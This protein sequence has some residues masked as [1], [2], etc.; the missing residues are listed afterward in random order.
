MIKIKLRR[1]LIY[2]L[3]YFIC[4]FLDYSVLGLVIPSVTGFNTLYICIYLYPI[5]NIIG[6]LVVFLYQKYS[7]RKKEKTQYFGIKFNKNKGASDGKFKIILLVFFAAY[8]NFYRFI[9]YAFVKNT[10]INFT[11]DLKLTTIQIIISTIICIYAFEFKFKKHHK[12]SLIIISIFLFL[13]ISTDIIYIIYYKYKLIRV[14]MLQYFMSLFFYMGYSFNNCIEK[15]LVDYNYMNP[16]IILMLEGVFEFIMASI[17]FIKMDPFT[18]FANIKCSLGLFIFLFILYTLL[19][20]I[21]NI[22]RIY[23]NVIYS[24]MARSLV[25]YL[26][27]PII[28][29]YSFFATEDFYHNVAYFIIIEII[30][31]AISFFGCVFNEYIILYCFGLELETQDKIAERAKNQFQ[32]ELNDMSTI[33]YNNEN[34]DDIRKSSTIISYD[35]FGLEI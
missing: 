3:I 12:I 9:F 14:L 1:N 5:E 15:Y 34:D 6:G 23:C 35:G 19:Q 18:P 31:I 32:K 4:A 25:D 30:S 26:L 27:N 8:F 7:I 21:V 28:N 10:Y 29:I 2:L 22:Y 11:M 24:P 20:V 33:I 16:F 13:S 17:S